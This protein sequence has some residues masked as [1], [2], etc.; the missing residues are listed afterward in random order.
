MNYQSRHPNVDCIGSTLL[1]LLHNE[2]RNRGLTLPS[3]LS[4]YGAQ[5]TAPLLDFNNIVVGCLSAKTPLRALQLNNFATS[6]VVPA[7]GAH[8]F[9]NGFLWMHK[10]AEAMI[11][12]LEG[13]KEGFD[14]LIPVTTQ[15]VKHAIDVACDLAITVRV[16]QWFLDGNHRTALACMVFSLAEQGVVLSSTFCPYKAYTIISARFHPG[17]ESNR[18][19]EEARQYAR[20]RLVSYLRKRTRIPI[21]NSTTALRVYLE[22]HLHAI[23]LLPNTVTRIEDL[24]RELELLAGEGAWLERLKVWRA[25]GD[26]MRVNMKLTFPSLAKG[27]VSKLP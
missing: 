22:C 23:R 1:S 14:D 16:E 24:G 3:N 11:Q 13:E 7:G 9:Q 2:T 19:D 4:L 27:L 12:K 8:G 5:M 6:G 10:S 17:N 21:N 18:L 15:S 26:R 20:S 25:Q